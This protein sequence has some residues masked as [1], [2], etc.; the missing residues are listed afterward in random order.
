MTRLV[1]KEMS[2]NNKVKLATCNLTVY[3]R[4]WLRNMEGL[5]HHCSIE[6]DTTQS[7]RNAHHLC[8]H[9]LSSLTCLVEERTGTARI[10]HTEGVEGDTGCKLIVTCSLH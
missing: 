8:V 4:V 1:D 6:M 2:A 10:S 7:K 3:S 5:C 9:V